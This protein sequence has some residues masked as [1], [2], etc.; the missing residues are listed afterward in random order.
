MSCRHAYLGFVYFGNGYSTGQ[1]PQ[2][3][4]NLIGMLGIS[5]FDAIG[6][7]AW[8]LTSLPIPE[9]NEYGEPT[10]VYG[11]KRNDA[12][13][14]F[15][16]HLG[17]TGI[18][19]NVALS[20]YYLL[21]IRN[22]FFVCH[23]TAVPVAENSR[24]IVSLVVAPIAGSIVLLT[25]NM[26]LVYLKVRAQAAASNRWRFDSHASTNSSLST[27]PAPSTSKMERAVFWQSL[28]YLAAFYL[29]WPLLMTA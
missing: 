21:T 5:I 9:F 11:A 3:P 7:G 25:V 13:Q 23:V 24:V 12:A 16:I 15:F 19:Y 14:G 26:I 20:I 10:A 18:F 27:T 6:S 4:P 28:F 29:T 17:F 22:L 8:I 1:A 2:P